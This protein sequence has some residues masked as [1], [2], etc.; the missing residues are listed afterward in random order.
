MAE[1]R[2]FG[3][4]SE[5]V[6]TRIREV[7]LKHSVKLRDLVPPSFPEEGIIILINQRAG[8]LDSKITDR[9]SVVFMPFLSGG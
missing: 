3:Y 4:L 5:L 9:D 8:T 6:G 1:I 7:P 2:F